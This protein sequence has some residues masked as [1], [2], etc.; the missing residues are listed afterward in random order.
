[1]L[2]SGAPRQREVRHGD[3]ARWYIRRVLPYVRLDGVLDGA[4]ITL[5]DVTDLKRSEQEQARLAAIVESS[6]E[7]IV[8]RT[9]EGTITAWNP[10]AVRMFGY[11]AQE[12]IGAD[13]SIYVPEGMRQELADVDRLVAR[14]ESLPPAESV[15]LAKGGQRIPVSVTA[16]PIRDREG[17]IVGVAS[18]FR[19]IS[20]LKRAQ[21]DLLAELQRRDQFLAMLSHELRN[22]LV[23]L[24][25]C[26]EI[27]SVDGVSDEE[28][29]HSHA[30]MRRQTEHLTKLVDQL[31]DI[32]RVSSGKITLEKRTLEIGELVRAAAEDARPTLK[33]AGLKLVVRVPSEPLWVSGDP[34]RLAQAVG[35]LLQNAAKFTDEGGTVT[36]Q[37]REDEATRTVTVS[38]RDT[39]IGMEPKLLAR[40]FEPFTQA[41]R[42]SSRLPGGLGLGLALVRS[43]LEAHGG[44]VEAASDGIGR[45]SQF[46]LR[47]PRAAAPARPAKGPA[48]AAASSRL[49]R[50]V[51]LVEDNPDILES[52]RILLELSGHEIATAED[53]AAALDV[54]REFRPEVV[55]CDIGLPGETDGY[56]LAAA[57]RQ[58]SALRS[59]YLVALTGYGQDSD[60]R[61]AAA[62]G[63]DLHVTK[64]ADPRT[65]ERILAEAPGRAL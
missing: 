57:M 51:L 38:V 4:V 26:L 5:L 54:A 37:A 42:E 17:Q 2:R 44:T 8:A 31:L 65:L 49:A 59:V 28:A 12:A 15:R 33:A 58:D 14:G 35:N 3:G 48:K 18:T 40:V 46:T 1:M 29:A 20:E 32:S 39:G 56:G 11:T 41:A 16:A 53:A 62:A 27:L 7:A 13:M 25:N 10:A 52:M 43:L 50:R 22:P 36:V 21:A 60:Q 47:L 34:T 30:V 24:R 55:F 9:F 6:H 61:R 23:P 64:P 19:D 63:F 45:G